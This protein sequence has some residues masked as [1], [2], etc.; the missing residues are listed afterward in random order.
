MFE[1]R[2]GG[3]VIPLDYMKQLKEL[4]RSHYLP[5]HLD[6]A[7]VCNAAVALG[8]EPRDICKHVDTVSLCVCGF[9]MHLRVLNETGKLGI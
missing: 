6:G 3:T 4:A 5:V 1:S 2:C 7:R 9:G 8:V